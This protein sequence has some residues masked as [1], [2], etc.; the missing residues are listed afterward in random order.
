MIIDTSYFLYNPVKI[1]NAVVQPSIGTNTPNNVTELQQAIEGVEYQFLLN[2]LGLEQYNELKAQFNPNGTWIDNPVQKWVDLVDGTGTWRGLRYT[3]G[4]VKK[5]LIAHYV[6]YTFLLD[7]QVYYTTTGLQRLDASNANTVDPT[8]KL[9]KEWNT[10][11]LEYQG[12]FNVCWCS[13]YQNEQSMYYFMQSNPDDYSVDYFKPYRLL[14]A[15]G[16]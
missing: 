10:F 11:V 14:N 15:W 2:A 8:S 7:G 13:Q 9:C 16:I 1:P 12:A 4:S 3:V 5:S 6:Y